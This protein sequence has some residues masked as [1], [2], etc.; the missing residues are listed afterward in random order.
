M[1]KPFNTYNGGKEAEGVYQ[2]IINLIPPHDLYVEHFCGN[3]T[4]YRH[5]RPSTS[6][7]LID[8][9]TA[10]ID[11]WKKTPMHPGTEIINTDAISFLRHF[12]VLADILKKSDTRSVIYIDPPY[13]KF[14]RK[15]NKDLY[16]HEMSEKQHCELL[17]IIKSI[18]CEVL[19]SSYPNKLYD[20]MLK[21][22][23]KIAFT[24]QTRS[25]MAVE[26]VWFNYE[27]PKQLHDYRYIG[28]NYRER[29]LIKGRIFRNVSKLI[30]M[31]AVERNSILKMI[32]ESN[33][34]C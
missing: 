22:W 26:N 34:N 10:V 4:I 12:S 8:L 33:S 23:N 11:A 7:I 2:R 19:I 14:S 29:E 20:E 17:G 24:A 28:D 27:Q 21:G 9:D 3:G 5:K 1:N 30:K 31:P 15:N 32:Y 6:S 16:K 13:P 25:G 18:P